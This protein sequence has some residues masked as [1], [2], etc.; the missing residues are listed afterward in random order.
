MGV[1]VGALAAARDIEIAAVQAEHKVHRRLVVREGAAVLE[2]RARADQALLVRRDALPA[3]DLELDVVDRLR[4]P[5]LSP[6]RR[7]KKDS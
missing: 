2:L 5:A 6:R 7:K 1:L 4:R 3:V